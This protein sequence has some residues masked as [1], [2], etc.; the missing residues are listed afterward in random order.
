MQLGCATDGLQRLLGCIFCWWA[1]WPTGILCSILLVCV[2]YNCS[3]LA[4]PAMAGPCC[5]KVEISSSCKRL[6]WLKCLSLISHSFLQDLHYGILLD[7]CSTRNHILHLPLLVT[8]VYTCNC[9]V[10]L[11][12]LK[13]CVYITCAREK[14]FCKTSFRVGMELKKVHKQGRGERM[15]EDYPKSAK[16]TPQR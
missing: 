12:T 6:F 8:C 10:L 9:F 11:P 7:V 2:A 4:S 16:N 5:Q 1:T 3:T 15:Q 13:R 14:S